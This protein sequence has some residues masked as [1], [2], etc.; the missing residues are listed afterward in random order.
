MDNNDI[1]LS[2]MLA[3][4]REEL[5]K[6]QRQGTGSDLKFQVDDIEVELQVATTKG[7]KGGGGVKLWVFN[8]TAE[9]NASKTATQKLKLKLKLAP[10]SDG[11]PVNVGDKDKRGG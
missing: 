4:L 1:T 10:G 2:E 3:E 5:L 6:A 8:A 9:G 11:K 7:G